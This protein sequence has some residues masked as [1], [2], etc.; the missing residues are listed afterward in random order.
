MLKAL[1]DERRFF[2]Q[3]DQALGRIVAF[4]GD[5]LAGFTVMSLRD[6]V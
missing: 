3:L 1:D 5:R 4:Y 6:L 2:M